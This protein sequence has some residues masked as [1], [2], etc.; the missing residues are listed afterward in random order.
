[1]QLTKIYKQGR[2][3]RTLK[4]NERLEWSKITN[5]VIKR[6]VVAPIMFL[7][8]LNDMKEE[9]RRYINLHRQ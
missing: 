3:T 5:G 7:M 2:Q 8:Y 4:R 1:M 6:S 9:L